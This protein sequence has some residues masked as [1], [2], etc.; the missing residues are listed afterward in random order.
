MNGS[1]VNI[2]ANN[3]LIKDVPVLIQPGQAKNTVGLALGYGRTK[4]GKAANNVGINAYPLLKAKEVSIELVEGKEHEFASIQLHHTMM[5]RDM[6]K[7]TPLSDYLE[8]MKKIKEGLSD[9]LSD[10]KRT[11]YPTFKGDLPSD[12]LSLSLIHISE[13]TR[14]Y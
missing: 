7:E 9:E 4:S 3:I 8:D 13:P 2:K 12:K 14:P 11:T 5:G 6:V 1:V 10:N